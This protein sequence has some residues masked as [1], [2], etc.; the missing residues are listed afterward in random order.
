MHAKRGETALYQTHKAA[1]PVPLPRVIQSLTSLRY[2]AALWVVLYHFISWFQAAFPNVPAL[3]ATGFMGVDFFF[4]LSGFVI[5]HVYSEQ[6]GNGR[7]DYWDFLVRRIARIYP[8]HVLTM[9][10]GIAM[11]I[12]ALNLGWSGDGYDPARSVSEDPGTLV[13]I[14]FA[15]LT[16]IHAWG[17]VDFYYFNGPSWSIS[18][19]WFAYLL[20]PVLCLLPGFRR[21]RPLAAIGLALG[22]LVVL[23]AFRSQANRSLFET[24]FNLGTLRILPE[25]LYGMA[26]HLL[27]TKW[28]AGRRSTAQFMLVATV[29]A[30]VANIALH[31]PLI[32]NALLM[33]PLIFLTADAERHGGLAWLCTP[34]PVLLGEISYSLYLWHWP[35]GA[36]L[37]G[38]VLSPGQIASPAAALAMIGILVAL[39]TFISY[40]SHRWFELPARS[41]IIAHGRSLTMKTATP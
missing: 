21:G 40:A 11:G 31:G 36:A 27:A 4:V 2:L 23:A 19:E 6:I 10:F 3:I 14:V 35:I 15:Q 26:L 16:L 32:V 17:A 1:A 13:R 9:A 30:L 22:L 24:T 5:A 29:M 8:L 18:A 7:F 39:I 38:T 37:L 25:F 33:G 12:I 28:S 34:F 20:F 41:W